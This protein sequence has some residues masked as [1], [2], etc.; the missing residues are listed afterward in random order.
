MKA[1]YSEFIKY[2]KAV[3]E[4]GEDL[5][6]NDPERETCPNFKNTGIYSP[7]PHDW[8]NDRDCWPIIFVWDGSFPVSLATGSDYWE[9]SGESFWGTTSFLHGLG[10]DFECVSHSFYIAEKYL[11]AETRMTPYALHI[12]KTTVPYILVN[13][14]NSKGAGEVLAL[15]WVKARNRC[16]YPEFYSQIDSD[17]CEMAITGY[18]D[19][20]L[21]EH[22][23]FWPGTPTGNPPATAA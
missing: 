2:L 6:I 19:S 1:P 4:S 17:A 16:R 18:S 22:L 20:P 5:F 12:M 21:G 7:P 10:E 15:F 3:D 14:R 13:S 23:G 11:R 8:Q 9:R